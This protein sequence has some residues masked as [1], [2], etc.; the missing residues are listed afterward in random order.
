ML[1]RYDWNARL[2]LEK[3]QDDLDADIKH[4]YHQT[5]AIFAEAEMANLPSVFF[6]SR[7]H[8]KTESA[9][10]TIEFRRCVVVPRSSAVANEAYWEFTPHKRFSDQFVLEHVRGASGSVLILH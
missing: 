9:G 4:A 8:R 6:G 7:M 10:L 3:A 1:H 2:R 5:D